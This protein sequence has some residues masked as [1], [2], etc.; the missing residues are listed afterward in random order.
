MY[1]DYQI[2]ELYRPEEIAN[3]Q[4]LAAKIDFNLN[5]KRGVLLSFPTPQGLAAIDYLKSLCD[6]AI[7]RLGLN[8]TVYRERLKFE[9][10]VID[11][12][13]Y[14]DYFLIVY[15]YVKFAKK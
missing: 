10:K 5:L 14:N 3:T 12:M 8:N 4:V 13:G 2:E 1:E 6:E 9:L 11:D 7:T 15:D